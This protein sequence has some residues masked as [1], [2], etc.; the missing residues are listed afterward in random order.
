VIPLLGM[1]P[2]SPW[3]LVPAAVLV[4]WV[5]GRQLKGQAVH[6]SPPPANRGV[7][8]APASASAIW[9]VTAA[10]TNRRKWEVP[11]RDTTGKWHGNS[12]RAFKAVRSGG[13]R[14]HAGADLYA[15]AGDYVLAPDDG[16]VVGRQPF[17][18]GTG[19]MLIELDSGVVVLLGETKMGGAEEVARELGQ[20]VAAEGVRVKRGQAVTK[21]GLTNNGSHMLHV[22][23][24]RSGTTKNHPWYQGRPAP[25]ELYDPTEFLLVAR[26][27]TRTVA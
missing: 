9:P 8:F 5:V 4:A 11:Y 16:V 15:N 2:L 13:D 17:L 20:P 12:S 21:V 22:E 14:F 6:S 18:N 27:N 7:P 3:L 10:S 26:D 24:Y 19:A 25:P 23:T 1:A